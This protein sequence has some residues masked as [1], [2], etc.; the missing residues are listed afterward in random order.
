MFSLFVIGILEAFFTKLSC[1]GE[2]L[3]FD[4]L[5]IGF[6]SGVFLDEDF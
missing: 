4:K 1:S 3:R 6:F 5:E 2:C